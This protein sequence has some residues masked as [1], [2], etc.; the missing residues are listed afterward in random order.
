MLRQLAAPFTAAARDGL[1]RGLSALVWTLVAV[2]LGVTG[3]GLLL[4]TAVMG[5]SRLTGPLLA[6]GL[7]GLGLVLL[8]L[9]VTT[10]RRQPPMAPPPLPVFA[11][12]PDELAFTFGF[13]LA[14]LIL[15]KKS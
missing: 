14:R 5:L 9:L 13:V 6:C 15:G 1:N 11:P 7:V 8:A 3:L 12:T 4:A 2:G 10:L